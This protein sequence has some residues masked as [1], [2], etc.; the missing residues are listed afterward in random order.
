MNK[1]REYR[2]I[3]CQRCRAR[4]FLLKTK[5]LNEDK[6]ELGRSFYYME[7]PNCFGLGYVEVMSFDYGVNVIN[8]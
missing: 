4:G 8:N 6:K 7:C 3:V 5:P 2:E 1:P